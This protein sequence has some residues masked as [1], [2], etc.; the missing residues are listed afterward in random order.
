MARAGACLSAQ[1][2][3]LARLV[4]PSPSARPALPGQ[5]VTGWPGFH[6]SHTTT[7][8]AWQHGARGSPP[9]AISL[10]IQLAACEPAGFPPR[11]FSG[12]VA[13]HDRS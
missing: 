9:E 3:R 8:T 2:T 13:E 7:Y 6:L 1:R 10:A 4:I 5:T 12:S 11:F